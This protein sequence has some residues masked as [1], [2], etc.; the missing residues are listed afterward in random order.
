MNTQRFL[1]AVGI[2]W[3]LMVTGISCYLLLRDP[4][5]QQ[6]PVHRYQP[7]TEWTA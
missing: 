5:V 3:I 2:L 6:K 7:V 4:Q 1:V